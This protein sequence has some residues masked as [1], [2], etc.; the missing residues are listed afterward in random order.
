MNFYTE[1]EHTYI[2]P[3]TKKKKSKQYNW[4]LS[5]VCHKA[6]AWEA[7]TPVFIHSNSPCFHRHFSSVYLLNAGVLQGS[8]SSLHIFFFALSLSSLF[9]WY[10]LP[11]LIVIFVKARIIFVSFSIVF[12]A[13]DKAV[14]E[15]LLNEWMNESISQWFLNL[16][17][18][19]WLL[20]WIPNTWIKMFIA[21]F[22]LNS[23]R[24]ASDP[25]CP[26]LSSFSSPQNLFLLFWL[27]YVNEPSTVHLL[28]SFGVIP[29]SCFLRTP[30][31][32]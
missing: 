11:S 28:F 20:S 21:Y 30:T 9:P 23:S 16:Y 25:T 14:S 26:K 27:S 12:N 5:L 4:K 32:T 13:W 10:Q 18:L 1:C 2:N 3:A 7:V 6:R 22:Y 15:Y 17:L 24:V 19:P 31:S 8:C 29:D